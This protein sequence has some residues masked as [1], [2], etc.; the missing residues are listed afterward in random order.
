MCAYRFGHCA[1]LLFNWMDIIN[2]T[3]YIVN[4]KYQ[5]GRQYLDQ[6]N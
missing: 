1:T 6:H 5:P 3:P 4:V 2:Y